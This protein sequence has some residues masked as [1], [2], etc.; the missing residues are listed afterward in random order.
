MFWA[1]RSRA[2]SSSNFGLPL[3]VAA[4]LL[5]ASAS[6]ASAQVGPPD[7]RGHIYLPETHGA[8]VMSTIINAQANYI[9]AVG[10]Y[11]ESIAIARR[12]HAAAAEHE[13]RNAIQWVNTYFEMRALNRAYR[14][15]ENPPYLDQEAKREEQRER[16]LYELPQLVLQGDVTDELNWMLD[17]LASMSIAYQ[18]VTGQ[19]DE[20]LGGRLDLPLSPH[21][22][23]HILFTDGGV[24][25][26]HQLVFRALDPRVL[27]TEWPLALRGP[28]FAEARLNFENVR[29]LALDEKRT[30]GEISSAT[31]DLLR[32]AVDRLALQFQIVYDRQRR[33]SSPL[34]YTS[35][36][37]PG[38]RY[39]MSLAH[40]VFRAVTTN[41]TQSFDG[42]YKFEGDSV[43]ELVQ[44]MSRNGL[45]FAS[46]KEGD[47]PTYKRLTESMRH[48]WMY[49]AQDES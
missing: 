27:E 39:L 42:S 3:A 26:G 46:P 17:E 33:L 5:A 22:V 2:A 28:E 7:S 29:E 11:A 8:T 34:E 16:R 45:Q 6:S 25:N 48:V 20:L 32:E 36:V 43:L 24:R 9:A 49:F 41:D 31:H 37:L 38:R 30:T 10:D 19:D 18:H 47:E 14:L 23:R 40:Q 13:M 35:V 1:I 44:H 4:A 12:H 15:R 21:D